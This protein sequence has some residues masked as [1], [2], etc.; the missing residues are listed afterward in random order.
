MEVYGDVV[1]DAVADAASKVVLLAL[2][3][4]LHRATA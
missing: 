2:N 3:G 4:R 1:T